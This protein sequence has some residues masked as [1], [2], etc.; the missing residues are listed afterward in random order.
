MSA[1]RPSYPAPI[2]TRTTSSLEITPH[3]AIE[4]INSQLSFLHLPHRI[5]DTLQL[6]TPKIAASYIIQI[7]TLLCKQLIQ[8]TLHDRDTHSHS[9]SD[10]HIDIN[11]VNSSSTIESLIT[12]LN[13]RIKQLELLLNINLHHISSQKIVNG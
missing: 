10:I 6:Y 8:S 7:I 3:Y 12:E 4:Q 5:I 1:T 2:H 11:T 13:S 9:H